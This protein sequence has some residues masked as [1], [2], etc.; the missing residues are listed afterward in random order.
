MVNNGMSETQAI[1]S[2]TINAAKLLGQSAQLGDLSV[3]KQ[4]DII[5]VASSP[6]KNIEMLKNVQFVM[7]AG[8]IYKQ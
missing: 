4:A 1:K 7:K 6:L 3:G 5:S 2:A 8:Q